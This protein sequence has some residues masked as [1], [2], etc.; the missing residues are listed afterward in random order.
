MK[1]YYNG[2]VLQRVETTSW[3]E[4]VEYDSTG[5]NMTANK[6]T[7]TFEGSV[8]PTQHTCDDHIVAPLT[9]PIS[10]NADV[11]RIAFTP[12]TG[13]PEQNLTLRQQLNLCLRQLSMPRGSFSVYDDV[14]G[15]RIFEAFPEDSADQL[16]ETERRNIDVA[17]GPKPQSVS[18]LHVYNEYARISFTIE[19]EKIR[20]LGGETAPFSELG[21]DPTSGFVVSNRCWTTETIDQNFYTTRTLTGQLKISSAK[22]SVHFYRDIYY[23]P[24][25]EGFMRESLRYSESEDG[26]T[27]SYAVTDRQVRCSA[28]FPATAFSGGVT[29]SVINGADMRLNMNLT[30]IGRPDC[31]KEALTSRALQAVTKKIEAFS[32]TSDG[33]IEKFDVSEN[34]GDPP[35]VSVAVALR[36]FSASKEAIASVNA[37]KEIAQLYASHISLIGKPL[38]FDDFSDG[39]VVYTY[40]RTKSPVPNPYGYDV[41]DAYD[42]EARADDSETARNPSML[43]YIK[44]IASA[45]CAIMPPVAAEGDVSSSEITGLAATK[46]IRDRD[47]ITYSK[48]K[49]GIKQAAINYPISYYKS[50]ITYYTDYSRI[51]LPKAKAVKKGAP[52]GQFT[53]TLSDGNFTATIT[54]DSLQ[55]GAISATGEGGEYVGSITMTDG[56]TGTVAITL[57]SATFVTCTLEGTIGDNTINGTATPTEGDPITFTGLIV[58]S[59]SEDDEEEDDNT[60]LVTFARPV[61][62]ALV[63]I[64]AERFNRLPELPDPD[65]VVKTSDDKPIS[66]TCVNTEIKICEPQ[67]ARGNDGVSYSIMARYEYVMSR[68]FKKDDE[69]WLLQNPTFGSSCYYP[70]QRDETGKLVEDKEGLQV[71]YNGTQL[72]HESDEGGEGGEGG[73]DDNDESQSASSETQST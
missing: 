70:K 34:L 51:A 4:T 9:S 11:R 49:T 31:P 44:S 40:Q 3:N 10:I 12:D 52:S 42:D 14:N 15:L 46:V 17:G 36:L 21:T 27:L 58:W 59:T 50:D 7:F 61:P 29:Y 25:E 67:A 53:G 45:P 32:K 1:V 68:Q 35:S 63:V 55:I 24:L 20:C 5:M 6:I 64:E 38:E 8:H 22:K 23:P 62:K 13:I 66:F 33:F 39:R 56:M 69:I 37:N 71:L 60:R 16:T 28:P 30:M 73:G 19:I 41:F 26:L 72:N 43:R 18:V 48:K 57:A 47:G 2:V 65:E 54:E